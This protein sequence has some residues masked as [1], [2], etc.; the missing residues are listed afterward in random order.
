MHP[1]RDPSRE[2]PWP[3]VKE[4]R[5]SVREGALGSVNLSWLDSSMKLHFLSITVES[6]GHVLSC[7]ELAS[8]LGVQYWTGGRS[9]ALALTNCCGLVYLDEDKFDQ[10]T[11]ELVSAAARVIAWRCK[12]DEDDMVVSINGTRVQKGSVD[13]DFVP[14]TEGRV[15]HRPVLNSLIPAGAKAGQRGKFLLE[16]RFTPCNKAV[17]LFHRRETTSLAWIGRL[18]RAYN[19]I[20]IGPHVPDVCGPLIVQFV[21]ENGASEAKPVA[22][23]DKSDKMLE[24]FASFG[25]GWYRHQAHLLQLYVVALAYGGDAATWGNPEV[26]L[27]AIKE[28]QMLLESTKIKHP[29]EVEQCLLAYRDQI[30]DAADQYDESDG[31]RLMDGAG[32]AIAAAR[33]AFA[34]WKASVRH[35]YWHFVQSLESTFT[36]TVYSMMPVLSIVSYKFDRNRMLPPSI[37]LMRPAFILP[38]GVLLAIGASRGAGWYFRH[39]KWLGVL[40][41]W[42]QDL[43]SISYL[44]I[45]LWY[46]IV[47]EGAFIPRAICLGLVDLLEGMAFLCDPFIKVIMDTG[48]TIVGYSLLVLYKK[49]VR[50]ACGPD[51]A[52]HG[53]EDCVTWL[54]APSRSHWFYLAHFVTL[55]LGNAASV[56]VARTVA[57][58]ARPGKKKL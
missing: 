18:E 53:R 40:L 3:S 28:A 43:V 1:P 30:D 34:G 16:G 26:G 2:Q 21:S 4:P 33:S 9:K 27:Q 5:P 45:A 14:L 13:D 12:A 47:P 19:S 55:L 6:T 39:G 56:V 52:M 10:P 37:C 31:R 24:A 22:V 11:P 32:N 23:C 54:N 41:F 17:L 51:G 7:A 58:R 38:L 20:A 57:P 46:G 29:E 36:C 25:S 48:R 42:L 35:D 8:T 49:I 44:P 15:S 50:N